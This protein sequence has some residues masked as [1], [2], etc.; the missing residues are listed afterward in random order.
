MVAGFAKRLAA[1]LDRI[2][3]DNERINALLFVRP[4]SEL[5]AEA[6]RI[7]E[8][9][10][11]KKAGRLA[12]LSI[13][14][15]A[16][17]NKTGFPV[18]C[19]SRTLEGYRAPYDA[20]VVARIEA[21]DGLIV[22]VANCDEFASGASG[23]HSA[24]GPTR[25]PR[26]ESRIPGGSS[27]GSAA[28]VAAGFCDA[29]LGT[30]TGGSVRNP[31]SHCGVVGIKPSY[32]RVSRHG[33]VDLAMSL[34]QVAPV[35]CDSA[36]ALRVLGVIAGVS[37]NDATTFDV[38]VPD[39][40]ADPKKTIRFGVLD[41]S[42]LEISPAVLRVFDARVAEL[43]SSLGALPRVSID[44]ISLAVATYYP[45]V[46]TEFFSATR[47]FDGRRYGKPIDEVGGDEV[48][49]RIFA[50]R[51]IALAEDENRFYRKSLV[52][53][54]HIAASFERAFERVDVILSPVVPMLP[55]KLDEK[56]LPEDEYAED[57]LTIP[58]NLAGICAASLPAG[59]AKGLPVGIQIL[60]PR[61]REDVLA[62][63]MRLVEKR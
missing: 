22:G 52:V 19:A 45:L 40:A 41:L 33:I 51:R 2:E 5:L 53:S 13:A 47:R 61:L 20:D 23:R 25:N 44:Y 50:G 31:A 36:T 21:E 14:I 9:M 1:Q 55:R 39:L 24:F 27:S 60:A 3:A 7:E 58:A 42:E 62:A 49:R 34:D 4:R 37:E 38:P 43:E 30:D 17:I 15:K 46:Y 28:S 29:A 59:E 63:A 6:K 54:E 57:A 18:S 35:A 12:G 48:K 11:S 10:A 8:K 16:N 56:V 32:G 26:D